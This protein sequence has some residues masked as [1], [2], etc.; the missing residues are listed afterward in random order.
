MAIGIL[1]AHLTLACAGDWPQFRGAA[2]TGVTEGS[3]IPL[4][5]SEEKNLAWKTEIPGMGWSQPIGIGSLVFVT[6]AVA[7]KRQEPPNY[8]NGTADP[9]TLAG[10]KASAPD[11]MIQWEVFALDLKTGAMKW[12]RNAA[13]GR[14]KYPIHPSNTYASETPAAD[15]RA[16]YGWFGLAGVIVAFDHAGQELWQKSLGVFRQQNNVGTG[17]SLRLFEGLLYVQCF[18][19]ELAV[20]VCLDARDGQEKW[21]LSRPVAGSAWNTP[22]IW[23]NRQRTELVVGAQKLLTSHDPLTG[24]EYWR[25]S[26][27]DMP[28]IP[29]F[30]GDSER[31]YFGYRDPVKGGPLYAIKSE[32]EGEQSCKEGD[33]AL[34]AQ[35]WKAPDAAPGIPSP[36]VVSGCVYVLN[37]SVLTCLD[38]STGKENYRK[39]LPGFRTVVASPIASGNRIVTVDE[40]GHALV[41]QAGPKFQILGQ[42]KLEDRFWASPATVNGALFLRGWKCLY[43]FHG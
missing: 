7:D 13:T 11:V 35:A 15:S 3:S 39:R 22:F 16:V 8:D 23:R 1:L 38:A 36:L 31:L 43:C 4:E 26:G 2:G 30:S 20:L 24:K 25:A 6:S 19:E 14:P 37:G 12:E 21:R 10:A 28:V 17:S 33:K 32:T 5:W 41:L 42:S 9:Y 29:S 40:A 34:L 18:S 27:L